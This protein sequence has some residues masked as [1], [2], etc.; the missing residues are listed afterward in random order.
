M[1][2]VLIH[3]KLVPMMISGGCIYTETL[4]EKQTNNKITHLQIG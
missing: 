3:D 2:V 4:Y 1:V